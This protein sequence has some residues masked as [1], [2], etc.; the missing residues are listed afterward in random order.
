MTKKT[1]KIEKIR[2]SIRTHLNWLVSTIVG[3]DYLSD[4][5]RGDIKKLGLSSNFLD[6]IYYSYFLGKKKSETRPSSYKTLTWKEFLSYTRDRQLSVEDLAGI[7]YARDSAAIY[8]KSLSD[9][10]ANGL[11]K[12]LQAVVGDTL[13]EARLKDI[14]QD[15]TAFAVLENAK[16]SEFVHKLDTR[17]RTDGKKDW[18]KIA[19]T[20][21]HRAKQQGVVSTITNKESI[22]SKSAGDLSNVSVVPSKGCC[23]DCSTLYTENGN[24][25][26]FV[27]RDLVANGINT[28]HKKVKNRHVDWHPTLPPM[29]PQCWCELVYVPPGYSWVSGKLALTAPE[30]L[31]KA[32]EGNMGAKTTPTPPSLPGVA[33]PGQTGNVAGGG[34]GEEFDYWPS[35]KGA[36]PKDGGYKNYKKKDGTVGWRRPK[37]SGGKGS[38]KEEEEQKD[39]AQVAAEAKAWGKFAMSHDVVISH[40]ETG[41]IVQQESLAEAKDVEAGATESYRVTIEGNGRGIMKPPAF[42]DKIHAQVGTQI[43]EGAGSCPINTGH[44]REKATYHA[45]NMMGVS[46]VPPTVTRSHEGLPVSVQ[47][48]SETKTPI[49]AGITMGKFGSVEHLPKYKDGNPIIGNETEFILSSIKEP[50]RKEKLIAS[51][52]EGV[53]MAILTNH[54]DQ[55]YGNVMIGD[56]MSLSFIDNT[57][58]LGYGMFG[59]KVQMHEEMSRMGMKVDVPDHLME[60]FKTTTLGDIERGIGKHTEDWAVGQ[61]FLRMKYMVHLQET[62]GHLDYEKFRP[63][64]RAGANNEVLNKI[65]EKHKNA[66]DPHQ[67][68]FY[69]QAQGTPRGG[70]WHGSD[71]EIQDEYDNRK[72]NGLLAHQLFD[73]YAKQWIDDSKKLPEGHPDRIAADKLD[74]IGIF[75]DVDEGFTLNPDEYRSSGKN[76]EYEKKIKPGMPPAKISGSTAEVQVTST[77]KTA[78]SA[79]KPKSGDKQVFKKP[80]SDAPKMDTPEAR[81]ATYL[82]LDLNEGIDPL[83]AKV[84]QKRDVANAASILTGIDDDELDAAFA[85]AKSEGDDDIID[86]T[87]D[88]EMLTMDKSLKKTVRL[89]I[90]I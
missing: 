10:L 60:R 62:E 28:N 84:T 12:N 14:I 39:P 24:P 53:A 33:S 1:N 29:H 49:L 6:G 25:K 56:D 57:T 59:T 7:K 20:E 54:N 77:K 21:M 38:G 72:A 45:Y 16:L 15:E 40:L 3:T 89:Y 52:K 2:H 30:T 41:R 27:L 19:N 71:S 48:W 4:S 70:F 90:S 47:Q 83:E 76:R 80:V 43:A 11:F 31:A 36:P 73:S 55:H 37:G 81:A 51:M 22:Y 74:S 23:T 68:L 50:E 86:L 69:K 44:L 46:K 85:S 64:I 75:M 65:S 35:G 34:S 8:V 9:D 17:L 79:R 82:E 63:T 87:D 67:A 61:T 32:F 42:H 13:T 5:E 78:P 58:C 26:V 88:A 66:G 18:K